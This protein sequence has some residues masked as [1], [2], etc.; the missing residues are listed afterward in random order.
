MYNAHSVRASGC[1][2]KDH[3]LTQFDQLVFELEMALRGSEDSHFADVEGVASD[4]GQHIYTTGLEGGNRLDRY[5]RTCQRLVPRLPLD[6]YGCVLA[7]HSVQEVC[8]TSCVP[9]V[10]AQ[11]GQALTGPKY[12]L[13][14]GHDLQLGVC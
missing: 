10:R 4:L 11:L 1:S 14:E 3:A 13:D 2:G 5:A 9:H 6:G 8:Q 7:E 12:T